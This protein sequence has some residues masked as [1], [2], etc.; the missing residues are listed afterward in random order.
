[1]DH[2]NYM[3][4]ALD[5]AKQGQGTVH[6][7]PLV[8]AVIVKDDRIIGEGYHEVYGGPHAEINAFKN[9]TEDVFGATMY[10]TLEP[11][12]HVGKTPPCADAII[13]KGIKQV[14]IA[15][16]DPNP[17]VSG[18][19]INKL[20][21]AG[22]QVQTGVLK[23]QAKELNERFLHYIKTKRP[24]VIVKTAM[25]KNG[26]IT[27]A[28]GRWVTGEESRKRVHQ[29]RSLTKAV[30]VGVQTVI[31]DDPMLN[32]RHIQSSTQPLR[33]VLDSNG[34][35]P[36]EAKL[37]QTATEIPTWI[38]VNDGVDSLWKNN[39]EQLGVRVIELPTQTK[40]VSLREVFEFLGQAEIDEVFI[41]P[42]RRLLQSLIHE[43]WINQWLVFES[44]NVEPEDQLHF[45]AYD[46]KISNHFQQ[47][48]EEQVGED[49]LRVFAPKE[50]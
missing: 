15:M 2:K 46:Y 17:L 1:M 37:V 25:S 3:Q 16:Q 34:R 38:F 50:E 39:M 23:K 14:V 44:P 41:E 5:L 32:V 26:K 48:K 18:N 24:Y 8:G 43:K 4:R 11:C 42:G 40:R 45:L 6:P 20:K 30:L 28:S 12:S 19:G 21:T 33:V 35:T 27:S 22:I 9:A 13:A 36:V 49:I 7:N 29:Y 31:D 10:V 47:V